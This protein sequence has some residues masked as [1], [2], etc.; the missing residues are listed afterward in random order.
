MS[1]MTAAAIIATAATV[2]PTPLGGD[3]VAIAN[4]LANY[5]QYAG[6]TVTDYVIQ[7]HAII[8]VPTLLVM[9]I[10]HFLLAKAYG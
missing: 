8:S 6:L 10:A 5:P 9:A 2:M 3:N 1:S 4:E 7:Y